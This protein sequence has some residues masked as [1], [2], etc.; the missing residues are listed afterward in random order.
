M[1]HVTESGSSEAR[2]GRSDERYETKRNKSLRE[3]NLRWLNRE[4]GPMRERGKEGKERK[5]GK[6]MRGCHRSKR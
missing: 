2:V 4:R 3:A 5:R 1:R 6:K